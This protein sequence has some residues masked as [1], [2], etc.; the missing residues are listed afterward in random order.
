VIKKDYVERLIEQIADAIARLL[1]LKAEG[2]HGEALAEV[3]STCEEAFGLEYE[4]LVGVDAASAASILGTPLKVRKFA[5]LVR[6]EAEALEAAGEVG[7]AVRRRTF[8]A[9]LEHGRGP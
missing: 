6:A 1:K 4:T 7:L 5:E 8:A 9:A 2:R 3:R